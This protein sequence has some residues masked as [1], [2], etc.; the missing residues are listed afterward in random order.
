MTALDEY[1]RIP[2]AFRV[3]S[4]LDVRPR[5]S[6]LGDSSCRSAASRSPT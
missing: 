2:I 6:G 4:V 3:E 5:D 1:A